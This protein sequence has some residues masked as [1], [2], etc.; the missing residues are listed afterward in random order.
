MSASYG[1]SVRTPTDV[2]CHTYPA[3]GPILCISE[4]STDISIS[5]RRADPALAEK[6]AA[7]L[8][9][10]AQKFYDA[11]LLHHARQ[12]LDEGVIR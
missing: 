3:D 6:F 7:D 12:A 4:A 9:V 2:I 5:A 8:L 10:A 11:T 1:L